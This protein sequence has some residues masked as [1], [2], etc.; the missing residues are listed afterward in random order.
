MTAQLH[1]HPACGHGQYRK[2]KREKQQ[3]FI[4]AAVYRKAESLGLCELDT[5]AVNR[6]A[7]TVFN[8]TGSVARA[9]S[10]ASAMIRQLGETA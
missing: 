7:H 10:Q 9:L 2:D 3:N 8:T 4:T 1:T 6:A 5:F